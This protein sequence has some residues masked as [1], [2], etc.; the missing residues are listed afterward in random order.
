M[1]IIVHTP[2]LETFH[3]FWFRNKKMVFPCL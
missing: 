2:A 1:H 3:L